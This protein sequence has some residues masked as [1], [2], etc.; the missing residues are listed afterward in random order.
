VEPPR[1]VKV[2]TVIVREH[3]DVMHEVLVVPGGFCWHGNNY[4]SLSTITKTIT[5]ISWNG[6][7]FF[8][9]RG[10]AQPEPRRD[11]FSSGR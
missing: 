2:D 9:L 4:D 3:R 8:G 11:A 5:G 7:R 10:A 6:L 1:Q